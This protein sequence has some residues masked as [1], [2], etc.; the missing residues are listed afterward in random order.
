MQRLDVANGDSQGVVPPESRFG[1][2]VHEHH[3][4]VGGKPD[5]AAEAAGDQSPDDVGRGGVGKPGD[6]PGVADMRSDL[7]EERDAVAVGVAAPPVEVD[8]GEQRPRPFVGNPRSD[9]IAGA[10]GP[11]HPVVEF[12]PAKLGLRKNVV[13]GH[14]VRGRSGD[15]VMH[16][17]IDRVHAVDILAGA[18]LQ[19][20]DLEEPDPAGR[21]VELEKRAAGAAQQ[22][23]HHVQRVMPR[24]VAE[25]CRV[26]EADDV[27]P[28]LS[29]YHHADSPSGRGPPQ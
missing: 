1:G 4:A 25:A 17:R 29:V 13:V 12:V 14:D 28:T 21:A 16:A 6:P 18:G 15:R 11:L 19:P 3:A 20:I 8:R 27:F 9:E 22:K 24:H 5:N 7:L 10:V 26:P 23:R 2:G